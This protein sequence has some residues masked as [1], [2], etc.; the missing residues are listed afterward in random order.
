MQ[1]PFSEE[2]DQYRRS[3]RRFLDAE[4]EPYIEKYVEAGGHDSTLWKKAG[5]AGLLGVTI[6]EEYGGPGGD[7]LFNIIQ[8]DE[9][10]R[11]LGGATVGSSI[12]SD[13][14]TSLLVDYG[15]HEQKLR[16]CPGIIS[17]ETI[18]AFAVTEPHSGSDFTS[19][20]TRAVRQDD[21]WV[22]NGS[23][24]FISNVTKAGLIY[25]FAKTNSTDRVTC[26]LLDAK[27]PG[28]ASSKLKSMGQPAGNVG[29][30][31]LEN[32][33]IPNGCILGKENEG[34]KVAFNTFAV[35]RLCI[36]ARALAEAELAFRLTLE[37]VKTRE[38]FGH[39]IFEYQ[40]TQFKLAE[41]KTALE[42]AR[43]FH[44]RCIWDYREGHLEL[45]RS[46][47]IKLHA[48]QTACRVVDDCVQ[49][50]GGAG[51]MDESPVSRIYT[52]LRLSRIYAGTDEM[53]KI[54]IAR[55]L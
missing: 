54:A 50:H 49:L 29:Q 28:L 22:V 15:T 38:S 24:T 53:Q 27:S 30:L 13:L 4:L 23:K 25:L 14:A 41:M 5:K 31:F 33:R 34:L 47:M 55:T 32:V 16:W 8:S 6:P 20:R 18:Q 51:W 7:K 9:V 46:A 44:D 12:T 36:A 21:E 19:M 48:A 10:G 3:L 39:K 37:F 52:S 26:F 2:H 40:N 45:A 35:D 43:T 11:S 17:G 42:V 1:S